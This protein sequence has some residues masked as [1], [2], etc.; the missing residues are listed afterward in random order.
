MDAFT[1]I[2]VK[3]TKYICINRH[4][5]WHGMDN[6]IL[7]SPNPFID[8][9][10]LIACPGCREMEL[11]LACD[12]PDCWDIASCGTP[13]VQGYRRTCLQHRPDGVV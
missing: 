10:E 3:M 11:E 2:E 5:G 1:R 9:D 8:G 6:E 12:E 13:I 4:C 7:R